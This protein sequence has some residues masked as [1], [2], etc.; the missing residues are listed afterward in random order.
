MR[1]ITADLFQ[2]PPLKI[3]GERGVMKQSPDFIGENLWKDW[4]IAAGK[5]EVLRTL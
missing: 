2:S 1:G 3:K 5:A 4:T